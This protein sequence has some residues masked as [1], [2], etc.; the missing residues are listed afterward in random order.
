MSTATKLA[1]APDGAAAGITAESRALMRHFTVGEIAAL[2]GLS[3]DAV[4]NIFAQEP[5][6]LMLGGQP[7]PGKRRGHVTLRIPE[8]VLQR[9]H[10]RLSKA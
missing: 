8:D 9:V 4:R 6:V 2:W 3:D 7:K 10:R 5:G 1:P